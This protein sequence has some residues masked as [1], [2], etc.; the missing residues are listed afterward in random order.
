MLSAYKYRPPINHPC[1]CEARGWKASYVWWWREGA[2]GASS[3]RGDNC[4]LKLEGLRAW[5][6]RASVWIGKPN[7]ERSWRSRRVS[8]DPIQGSKAG[9]FRVWI[10]RPN[11]NES[12]SWYDGNV[13]LSLFDDDMWL[14]CWKG[15]S[16]DDRS[17]LTTTST[18]LGFPILTTSTPPFSVL[19][20]ASQYTTAPPLTS[21]IGFPTAHK[22]SLRLAVFPWLDQ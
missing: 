7:P 8:G 6:T 15:P 2:E 21:C 5:I 9:R 17:Q 12:K 3:G 11:T 20:W 19:Y 13:T 10:G 16:Q 22:V 18:V 14:T 4:N 1:N